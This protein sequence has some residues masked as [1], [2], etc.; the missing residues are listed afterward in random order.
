[1][2][3]CILSSS[4]FNQLGR[5]EH[6]LI[7]MWIHF[8]VF[9]I[10]CPLN[11]RWEFFGFVYISL[12]LGVM[13]RFVRRKIVKLPVIQ[14]AHID[15]WSQQCSLVCVCARWC[16][17]PLIKILCLNIPTA[18]YLFRSDCRLSISACHWIGPLRKDTWTDSFGRCDV[19]DCLC[20][21]AAR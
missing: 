4:W 17:G 12:R 15:R 7:R 9:V 14:C 11:K 6:Q 13:C 8:G 5:M 20:V 1:M 10:V 3:L 21:S 2:S 19:C 18:I 16:V